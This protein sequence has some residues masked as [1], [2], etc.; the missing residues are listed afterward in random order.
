ML[1]LETGVLLKEEVLDSTE[2]SAA[3][4]GRDLSRLRQDISGDLVTQ[5][6]HD[7]TCGFN[8]LDPQII[9]RVGQLWILTHMSPSGPNGIDPRLLRNL[10]DDHV[11]V[12]DQVLPIWHLHKCISQAV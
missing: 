3:R 9:Q 2:G 11:Q 12:V 4:D 10:Y 5:H 7:G 1:H 8:E 6:G